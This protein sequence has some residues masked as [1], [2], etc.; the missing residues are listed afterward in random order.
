MGRRAR[1]PHDRTPVLDRESSW[2]R[3]NE[4]VLEE[5]EDERNP[6]LERLR[7]LTIFHTNLDE[8]FMIRVSG[9]R[10]QVVAG[11]QVLGEDGLSPRQ[12]ILRLRRDVRSALS[13]AQACLEKLLAHDFAGAGITLVHHRDL[14]P[15]L[16]AK[17][18]D[19][20]DTRV[21]PI[22]T[23]L[24]VSPH[25][26]FPFISNL[27]LNMA[28][29]VT[30][31][32]GEWRLA[33]LKIPD[34]L[35]RYVNVDESADPA[36]PPIRLMAIEDLIAANLA[37]LFP[38][39]EV[40]EAHT[41]R[42]TRDADVEIHEDEADD[43]LK[44]VEV[45][46]RKRRLGHP[47]RLEVHAS[48]PRDM[49]TELQ[50]GLGIDETTTYP[51]EHIIDPT[52][53]N[54]LLQLDLP[55]YKFKP[56]VPRSHKDLVGP[57]IFQRIAKGD[58]LLHHP[59]DSFAPV[60][61]FV[62]QAAMDPAVLAI[63]MTLYRTSGD[64]P[65][66]A[67]LL[68][69]VERGKQ[70][71]AVVELKARFDE[72]NNIE[73]ARRLEEAGVHVIYGVAHLKI[74]G[75]L[76]LVVRREAEGLRRYVHI[77]T[78]NYNPVTSRVYTDLGLFTCDP[79]ITSDAAD[80]FNQITGFAVPPGFKSA[81]VAP[82]FMKD[83]LLELIRRETETAR[84]G[85]PARIIAKCNAVTDRQLIEALYEASRAGVRIDLLVRGM[86]G[87]IPRRKGWSEHITVRSVVGRFLEHSRVY[88][89]E[90]DGTPEAYIGS[91]DLMERN[92]DRRIEILVPIK[93]P[94]IQRWVRDTLLERY[95]NDNRRTR[96]MNSDGDYCRVPLDADTTTV[97]VHQ[98]FL[99]DLG[100]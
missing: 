8:F 16:Q 79:Q 69:A 22:L 87:L 43:L 86:C 70:V 5:A 44:Y 17:W 50:R 34:H 63:K 31:P 89:F 9:I 54:R 36:H 53:L 68:D 6:L 78:G 18:N 93:N 25:L 29:Y 65:A 15:E 28:L 56:F 67:A 66:V 21:H 24:A 99:R 92:L 11:V 19:W 95:L 64:S 14:E 59:F 47:V 60:A 33:R 30:S 32:E 81:L 23:P 13:R 39:M 4:R 83:R 26:P 27:S 75:K 57:R 85:R 90:N 82:E 55:A 72:K 88:W 94:E 42:V 58:V 1:T 51:I 38:G 35:P 7:F 71:A 91:A 100:S 41:F 3:F 98:Q 40:E 97:D 76:C 77:G 46:L 37:K 49:V 20:Y 73:W 10:Q 12:R 52:G 96:V 2:I 84:A 74:H 80:L 48:A 45:E 61:E 62:R